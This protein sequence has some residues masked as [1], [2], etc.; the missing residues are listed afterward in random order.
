[1]LPKM[2]RRHTRTAASADPALQCTVLLTDSAV[3]LMA[4]NQAVVIERLPTYSPMACMKYAN[5]PFLQPC[6][7]MRCKFHFA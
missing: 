4:C 1:M 7:G 5:L 2:P 3:L 6:E